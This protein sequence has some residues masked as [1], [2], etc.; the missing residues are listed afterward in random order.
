MRWNNNNN[1]NNNNNTGQSRP[2][3]TVISDLSESIFSSESES[4]S[5][6]SVTHSYAGSGSLND[7]ERKGKRNARPVSQRGERIENQQS[8]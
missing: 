5:S 3:M 8:K 1:N 2:S 6:Y 7:F 4:D